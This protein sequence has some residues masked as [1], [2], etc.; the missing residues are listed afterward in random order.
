MTPDTLVVT[1]HF[2]ASPAAV[3]DAWTSP[4]HFATW[5]GGTEMKVPLSTVSLDARAGGAWRADM[6]APDGRIIHWVGGYLAVERPNH[7]VLTM[8]D[9]PSA[10]ERARLEVSIDGTEEG[11]TMT[12]VQDGTSRFS[13]EQY[14]A[15]KAGYGVFFD[16]LAKMFEICRKGR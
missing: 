15:T 10:A 12:L 2:A 4:A 9:D 11:T 6:H 3:F 8:T 14:E 1:H 13:P 5:F 16:A 7:L